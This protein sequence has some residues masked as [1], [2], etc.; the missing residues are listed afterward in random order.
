M[1]YNPDRDVF[2]MY[3]RAT[4]NAHEVRR[5]AYSESRD[6]VAWTQ[7]QVIFDADELDPPMLYGMTVTPYQGVYLGFLQMYY[8]ANAGYKTGARLWRDGRVEKSG[9]SDIELAWSRDGIQWH[10]HPQRPI[11]LPT[12][13]HTV[14]HDWGIVYLNQ[15]IIE[16]G[17][18]LY[19]YYRGDDCLHFQPAPT[20]TYNLAPLRRDRFVSR[21]TPDVGSGPAYML[22]RPLLCPGGN[23]HIN[24]KTRKDG[25]VRVAVRNGE[26]AAD[27]DWLEA[28]NF[29]D[30]D[31][32]TGD[33]TDTT[34]NWR[35]QAGFDSLEGRSVR[36]HFWFHKAELFSFWFGDERA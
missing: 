34:V 31:P 5:I 12:G 8:G 29:E 36:L 19:L 11:F 33:A 28:W 7:P 13:V 26:G 2:M 25:F 3:R 35:Q 18:E 24:A 1:V 4:V 20:M 15:G 23:L 6:L 30:G 17:D 22:T 32:F 10:R 9:E 21:G 16:R 14:D 27:G